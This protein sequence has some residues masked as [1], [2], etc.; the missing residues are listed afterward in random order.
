MGFMEYANYHQCNIIPQEEFEELVTEVFGVIATNISRSLGP[1]GSSATILN[2]MMTEATKDGYSILSNY[3]FNNKY[4]RLVLN[5]IKAPCT[6]M[7]NT[8]GDGTTTVIALTNA[9]F[10]R[11]RNQEKSLYSLYRLPRELTKC[12][13][14]VVEEIVQKIQERAQPLDPTDY[15]KVFN[16]AYVVSNGNKEVSSQ[17]AKVYAESKSPVIKLKDSPTNR[18]YIEAVE[19]FSFPANAIDSIYVTNEDLSATEQD[20]MTMLFGQKITRDLLE[21]IIVPVSKVAHLSQKKLLVIAPS[22]DDYMCETVLGQFANAE[23]RQFGS[24]NTL[25]L[26][27]RM[28]DIEQG[29]RDDLAVI[30]RSKTINQLVL[31]DIK[32]AIQLSPEKFVS[33]AYKD[34]SSPMYRM[35]GH[36]DTAFISC[37]NGSIFT[38]QNIEQDEAYQQALK[39]AQAELDAIVRSSSMERQSYSHKIYDA[40]ARVLQL[41]M[42]NY[43]YYIGADS[44]LQKQILWDSIEDVVKCMRSAIRCGVV[45]G[46]QLTIINVCK[47]LLWSGSR[48]NECDA[49]T[50]S[51]RT[52]LLTMIMSACMEVYEMVLHGP[53]KHGLVKM[54]KDWNTAYQGDEGAAKLAATAVELGYNI[55]GRSITEN[56]VFDLETRTFNPNIITSAETDVMVLRAATELVKILISGNQCIYVDEEINSTHQETKEVYV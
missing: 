43:V 16:L 41:Q 12:L 17:I 6:K 4:K 42:K 27:Y 49:N 35:L 1:L 5:L 52:E 21:S 29:Q 53:D 22:Y 50:P 9:L 32:E 19:G 36:A 48:F 25:M 28:A 7:N 2:G 14:S 20:V 31:N 13:D 8:V 3:R 11:Y 18:S 23:I 55:I 54:I 51:L 45:P 34:P 33:D 47:N 15:D 39:N 30:L 37:T 10:Q 44:E 38:S 46:C 56:C 26:Q 24:V 40:R